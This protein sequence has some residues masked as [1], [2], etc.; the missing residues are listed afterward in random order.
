MSKSSFLSRDDHLRRQP[1]QKRGQQRV[2]KILLAAAEVFADA[3]FAAATVQQIADRA[4]TA[5]GSVYQFF[6]DKLAIFRA[7]FARYKDRVE[8]IEAAFFAADPYRPLRQGIDQYIDAYIDYLQDPIPRCIVLQ[9]Y[10]Q[11]IVGVMDLMEGIPEWQRLSVQRHGAFYRQRNPN[12]SVAKSELLSEVAHNATRNLISGPL[13]VNEAHQQALLAELKDLLYAYLQPH[14]GDQFLSV[15]SKMMI[16]PECQSDRVT[17][18]GHH[19]GRQRHVCRRCG[20]QFMGDY[21]DRG[22]PPETR[23]KCVDLYRQ[24]LSYREIERQTGVNHNTVISWV[25]KS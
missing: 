13:D 2:E 17:K 9:Y 20:R 11:P 15:H 6:P 3:G 25:K 4:S 22:Y 16:C 18:N 8:D 19:K 10:L 1:Q 24:G 23:Q 12:L 5:V 21:V 7:L 14:I